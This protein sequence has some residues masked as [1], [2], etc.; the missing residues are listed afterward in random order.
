MGYIGSDPRN[1]DSVTTSQLVDDAVTNAKLVDDVLFSSVTSSIVS[2][3]GNIT[4]DTFTGT[5]NGALSSSAQI[6]TS[7]SG[8]STSLSSSLSTRATTLES[9]SGSFA[10]DLVT[11]KGSGTAQGVGTSDSPT[12]AD[13]TITGT[14]TAQE[15]HTEFES[16]SVI[17]TSGSTIFGNSSDDIHNMTGSL[18]VSGSIN[19]NNG[20]LTVT[21][22]V[23]FN[24]DLDVDGTTNLDVVDID[25][26]VDM[27]STLKA[28]DTILGQTG[29]QKGK[30]TIQSR[31]GTATR[32]TNA[33][34]AVPYN[35]AS[36]SICMIGMDGQSSN[37][38]MHIGSNTS[39][40]MSPTY[41]DF[42]T[43]SDVNSQTNSRAM[44]IQS[45]QKVGIGT[46]S[47]TLLLHVNGGALIRNGS[48]AGSYFDHTNTNT[49]NFGYDINSNTGGWV[50]YKGYQGGT[51]QF[52]DFYVGNGKGSAIAI[53]EGSTSR[54]GIGTDDPDVQLDIQNT[55]HAILRLLAG[56]NKSASMRLRNDAQD[57][58]VNC[59]TTDNFAIYDQT[60]GAA[61]LTIAPSTYAATFGGD[62]TISK[63]NATLT[64]FD[65]TVGNKE[66]IVIDRNTANGDDYQE[67]RWK[68][69][70]SNYPGGYIRHDYEDTNNSNLY[71]GVRDSGTPG[72][73]LTIDNSKNATFASRVQASLFR[74]DN[75]ATSVANA[76]WTDLNGLTNLSAGLY[77][78]HAYKDNYAANDWSARGIVE[79]TGHSTIDGDFENQSGFQL[80]VN[81]NDVQLYHTL[82]NTFGITVAWIKIG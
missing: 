7:I 24:G 48:D 47:A 33:I 29:N 66:S 69:Q 13:A 81:G 70:G 76:T 14:L 41:I 37:N 5:F 45:D 9:A 77:I 54:V 64:T 28:G 82:G 23:D 39:D 72:T 55:D 60:G 51:T 52:R 65:S 31:T 59:Q 8:S 43:A 22:N 4:A 44:R 12:F 15:V 21:N 79:A 35:D 46:D 57:W 27:A 38:E 20:T 11:L 16:A 36:E 53:F 26:A 3:S 19:L 80:R 40:F 17:F 2:A 74:T 68:L 73:A 49:L 67:I 56:T 30:L 18:N 42:F 63:S 71:F 1:K 75:Q 61:A 50:N 78:I 62:V 58:D 25:G 6:A 32:K 34:V 10:S